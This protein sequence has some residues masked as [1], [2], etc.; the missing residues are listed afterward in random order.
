MP[1]GFDPHKRVCWPRFLGTTENVFDRF[2]ALHDLMESH[3]VA[4]AQVEEPAV[5]A[6]AAWGV[7]KNVGNRWCNRCTIIKVGTPLSAKVRLTVENHR[8][9]QQ[10]PNLRAVAALAG[11]PAKRAT[12][13][14]RSCGR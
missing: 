2:F 5:E 9:R 8:Q 1:S 13:M 3:F 12:R 7:G 4:A 10:A 6:A 14:V 11:K